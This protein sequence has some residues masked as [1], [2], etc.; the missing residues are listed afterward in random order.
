SS[1]TTRPLRTFTI[2]PAVPPALRRL[3]DLALNLRWS[4]D[5]ETIDLFRRLDPDLWES[6]GHSPILMLGTIRQER[7][8]E[9]AADDGFVAQYRRVCERLDAY[10]GRAGPNGET[11]FHPWFPRTYPQSN[12]WI[13]YFLA[14]V[15]VSE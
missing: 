8:N 14:G 11:A 13:A 1:M 2:V 12:V 10:V 15:G 6:S 5:R 3:R 9:A 4:W 7:L